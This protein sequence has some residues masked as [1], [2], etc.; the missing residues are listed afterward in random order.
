MECEV[1]AQVEAV[2]ATT[3]GPI[4]DATSRQLFT[5]EQELL[6]QM[7]D[8]AEQSRGQ[9]D[10]RTKKLIDWIRENMC[11]NLGKKDAQWNDTRVLIFTE[12]SMG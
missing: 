1:E 10:A 3:V 4:E 7:T 8:I 5:R 9:T 12:Y 11:P 6:A 2:S